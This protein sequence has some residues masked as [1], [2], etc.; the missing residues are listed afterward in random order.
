MTAQETYQHC[1]R[2]GTKRPIERLVQVTLKTKAI[3]QVSHYCAEVGFCSRTAK[4]G[5]GKMDA[6]FTRGG[7][8]GA[9]DR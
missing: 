2:C 5:Q 3:N 7:V 9:K 6:D 4:V 8:P 1:D